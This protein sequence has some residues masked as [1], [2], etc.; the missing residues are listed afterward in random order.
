MEF[1][2]QRATHWTGMSPGVLSLQYKVYLKIKRVLRGYSNKV[3]PERCLPLEGD[4]GRKG[5]GKKGV[6][7][8]KAWNWTLKNEKRWGNQRGGATAEIKEREEQRRRSGLGE[9]EAFF[10]L[11]L[12]F[13]VQISNWFMLQSQSDWTE[14]LPE[15]FSEIQISRPGPQTMGFGDLCTGTQPVKVT[16]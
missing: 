13:L 6:I 12:F 9:W 14:E 15:E 16:F 11:T 3:C 1:I 10:F 8:A 5:I 2:L 7:F 4:W